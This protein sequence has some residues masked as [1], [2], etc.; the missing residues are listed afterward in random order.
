MH[1]K[2]ITGLLVI[3]S[4][5]AFVTANP[6]QAQDYHYKKRSSS[7]V[8]T[9]GIVGAA[10][11]LLLFG[12][13]ASQ[14]HDDKDKKKKKVHKH[15]HKTHSY[16]H[17]YGKSLLPRQC[18]RRPYGDH[19]PRVVKRGCLNKHYHGA[20]ALPNSCKVKYY[21]NGKTRKAFNLRCLRNNGFAVARH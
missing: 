18:V 21:K 12:A 7:A 9:E 13:I 16:S 11:A 10:A 1:S 8:T 15:K 14:I 5:I 2:F 3:A 4:T 17:N 6:A 20:R 19:G